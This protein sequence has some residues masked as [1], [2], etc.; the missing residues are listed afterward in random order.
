MKSEIEHPLLSDIELE[1]YCHASSFSDKAKILL[2][3]QKLEW[4]MLADNYNSLIDKQQR[5]LE[6][7][8]FQIQLQFNPK[9]IISSAA[10]IDAKSLSKR[11]CF[12]CYKHLPEEQKGLQ[13]GDDYLILCNPYP[14]FNQ[15]FPLFRAGSR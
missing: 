6:F 1:K 2:A 7:D 14:I 11:C 9:R 15:H 10:K 3:Q 8:G 12:L 4:K 5:V 13:Y